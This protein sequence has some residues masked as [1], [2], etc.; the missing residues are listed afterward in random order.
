M[1]KFR[2]SCIV[3]NVTDKFIMARKRVGVG[4]EIVPRPVKGRTSY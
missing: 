1:F 4:F 2:R 3:N